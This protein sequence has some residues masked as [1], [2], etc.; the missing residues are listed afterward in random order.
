ML[1]YLFVNIHHCYSYS[2]Q[3]P[4]YGGYGCD[5][6]IKHPCGEIANDCTEQADF[7]GSV[8]VRLADPPSNS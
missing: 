6:V 5:G 1:Y 2:Q 3:G 4:E 8:R 7:E